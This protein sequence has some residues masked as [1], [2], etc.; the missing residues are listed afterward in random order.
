MGGRSG[1]TRIER[2]GELVL[3]EI[4]YLWD[5]LG[6]FALGSGARRS[7]DGE[8]ERKVRRTLH[9]R[10]TMPSADPAQ[11]LSLVNASKPFYEMLGGTEV[12]LLQNVDDP[13]K[14]IQVIEYEDAGVDGDQSRS[15]SRAT[16]GMQGYLHGVAHHA[17]G[18]RRDRRVQGRGA[19]KPRRLPLAACG[20]RASGD[21]LKSS[22]CTRRPPDACAARRRPP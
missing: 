15:A 3:D 7:C 11:L 9:L 10:F 5:D 21:K 8:E 14:F 6:A 17:A 1:E 4:A 18:R 20:Q 22:D 13:G 16:R 12:R 2:R 19:V